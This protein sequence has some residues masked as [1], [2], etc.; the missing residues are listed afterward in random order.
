MIRILGRTIR[1]EEGEITPKEDACPLKGSHNLYNIAAAY[2]VCRQKGI[3]D[4]GFLKALSTFVTLPHRLQF[5][6]EYGGIFYYD[7]SISTIGAT[8]IGAVESLGSV[9]SLLIGGMD[10]GIDYSDLKA[11]LPGCP[12]DVLIFL[13]DSG[14]RVLREMEEK[15][16]SFGDKLLLRAKDLKE[17]VALAKA[18]TPKGK[19]C[20]L[21]P[22][23]AS[24]GFFKDFEERGDRFQQY[25]KEV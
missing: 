4:E 5:V 17:G 9:G 3:S 8:L 1:W 14:W 24:Y 16:L 10:R 19:A 25:V 18:H 23:A 7:D 15:G 21:S 2:G 13:P 11:F 20:L 22:A 6:G 12:A